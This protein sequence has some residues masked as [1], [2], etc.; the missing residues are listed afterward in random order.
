MNCM[1]Y[2]SSNF[3]SAIN[4]VSI[5]VNNSNFTSVLFKAAWYVNP[6]AE[7]KSTGSNLKI[8]KHIALKIC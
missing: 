2:S 3:F 4:S 5:S 8:L 1:T 7:R 6:R